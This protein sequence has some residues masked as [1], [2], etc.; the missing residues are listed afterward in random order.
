[1]INNGPV[2]LAANLHRCKK[3]SAFLLSKAL[4]LG[5]VILGLPNQLLTNYSLS[6]RHSA[7]KP[8]IS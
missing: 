2:G 3:K 5:D 4:F 1:M 8:L 7:L 6:S